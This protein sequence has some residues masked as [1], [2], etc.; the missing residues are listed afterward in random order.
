MIYLFFNCIFLATSLK[1]HIRV[2][3]FWL[4]RVLGNH[5]IP[6]YVFGKHWKLGQTEINFRV[7]RKIPHL[8]RKTISGF[9]LPSKH[10]HSSHTLS[11]LLTRTPHRH[12]PSSIVTE[13]HRARQHQT[14]GHPLLHANLSSAH[15]PTIQ[16]LSFLQSDDP[17]SSDPPTM[18]FLHCLNKST[19]DT[20]YFHPIHPLFHFDP[21][22]NPPSILTRQP[23]LTSPPI[24]TPPTHTL[25]K[26]IH[27]PSNPSIQNPPS[28]S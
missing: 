9:I 15:S 11:K 6:L 25:Q 13:L 1:K 2:R 27:I 19:F 10:L 23:H 24:H 5:F 16:L 21:T 14:Q 18:S 28:N 4:K 8:A 26:M 17:Q 22:S 12:S 7:N 3:L 20:H